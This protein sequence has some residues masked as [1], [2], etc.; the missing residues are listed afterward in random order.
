MKK[1]ISVVVVLLLVLLGIY[2]GYK[3][4]ALKNARPLPNE[5]SKDEKAKSNETDKKLGNEKLKQMV[6][7]KVAKAEASKTQSDIDEARKLI[8]TLPSGNDK[9]TLNKKID[10]II[11]IDNKTRNNTVLWVKTP[12]YDGIKT[13]IDGTIDIK[14]AKLVK[15]FV[16]NKELPVTLNSD[17]TF[18]IDCES[19]DVGKTVK[20]KAYD[21]DSNEI[22]SRDVIR[23][24]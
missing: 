6:N 23:A 16:E 18:I 12:E 17:G 20:V 8:D 21:K 1:R 3:S 2:Y 14:K 13:S 15:A 5:L 19:I 10:K 7:D 11:A 4:D 24:L 22:N 9:N